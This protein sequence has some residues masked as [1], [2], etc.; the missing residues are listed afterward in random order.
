M[1]KHPPQ[2][3]DQDFIDTPAVAALLGVTPA[4]VARWRT[5]SRAQQLEFFA[6]GGRRLYRRADVL[7]FVEAGRRKPA[8]A[9]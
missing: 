8:K 4:T 6:V 5:Q 7:A 2:A 9:R 3:S 1:S